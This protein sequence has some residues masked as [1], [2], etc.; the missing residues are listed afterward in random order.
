MDLFRL[1]WVIVTRLV[2]LRIYNVFQFS[3]HISRDQSFQNLTILPLFRYY[4]SP[5]SIFWRRQYLLIISF[6]LKSNKF[7]ENSCS[8]QGSV[9]ILTMGI[10]SRKRVIRIITY[11]LSLISWWKVVIEF[12][13]IIDIE[14]GEE[15][16]YRK[17][18]DGLNFIF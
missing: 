6:I 15:W 14:F 13:S 4:L 11:S 2:G 3:K 9:F 12:R 8:V 7:C 17:S 1:N 5:Q 18:I 16:A 10:G